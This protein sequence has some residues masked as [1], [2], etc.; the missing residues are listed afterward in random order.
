MSMMGGGRGRRGGAGRPDK[1]APKATFKQL[2]PYLAQ[3]KGSLVLA[4]V[5]SLI[6]AVLSLAQPLLTGQVINAVQ[7]HQAVVG[8]VA[9]LVA[10]VV[11]SGFSGGWMYYVLTRTGEGVVLSARRHLAER[12]LRLPI[13]EYDLRRTGDLVSR[14]SGDTT[15]L[16]NVLT[17]GLVDA[18]GGLLVFVGSVIAMAVIDPVLLGCTLLVILVAMGAIVVVARQIRHATTKAQERVGAMSA[19]VER[20]LSAVRTIRAARAEAREAEEIVTDAKQAYDQG[21]KIARISSAISPIAGIAMNGAFIVVLG[22][23]GF[24]VASG[25]TTVANLVSFVLLLFLMIRPIGQAFG[26]YS[27]VQTG[28]G[29]LARIQEVLDI[30]TEAELSNA[31]QASVA[32]PV[33]S[34]AI[35]FE[36]VDFAYAPAAVEPEA[37][38]AEPSS[39]R[40]ELQD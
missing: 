6:G 7:K 10:L 8:P 22:V 20:A 28:L 36:N 39:S 1:N 31:P 3:H 23:G 34:V 30:V 29:A 26:A 16:R 27:S 12:L 19:A 21:V 15:L 13:K 40:R 9:L 35:E 11:V 2:W 18:V 32:T 38:G 25:A 37:E 17:Q 5:L 24:R 4:A 33:S 14:V